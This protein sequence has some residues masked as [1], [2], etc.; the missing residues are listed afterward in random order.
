[1]AD[2]AENREAFGGQFAGRGESGYPLVR[3]L[4]VMALRSHLLSAL[5]FADYRTGE[6]TLAEE[7]WRELPMIR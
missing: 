2:T 4:G 1:M 3:M 7:L 5:R 6:V